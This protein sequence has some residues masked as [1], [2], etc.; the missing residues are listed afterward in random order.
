MPAR[1]AGTGLPGHQSP[2]S[3]KALETPHPATYCSCSSCG[4]QSPPSRKALET[5][6]T[7]SPS[8]SKNFGIKAPPAERHWRP[9]LAEFHNLRNAPKASKP[10][11]PKGI[12]DLPS[13]IPFSRDSI[14]GIKAPPAERHWRHPAGPGSDR[15]RGG[16][17]KAPP[18][19]RHWRH[20][21]NDEAVILGAG[22]IKAPP[23][24]RHWRPRDDRLR[25]GADVGQASKPPQPK[26]IGDA[27]WRAEL[28]RCATG[29]QS[30]PSRKALETHGPLDLTCASP[31]GH[32]SPPSRKALETS[33]RREGLAGSLRRHQSPPSRKA[34]ETEPFG[35][36]LCGLR[37]VA[38]KPPQPK[39]IGDMASADKNACRRSFWHQSPPSR[40]ALETDRQHAG[41][42]L[43][44]ESASKPPQPK[45]IGDE[46]PLRDGVSVQEGIKAPP[47][48][49]HWRP[50]TTRIPATLPVRVAS[51]PPQPKGIGDP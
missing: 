21:H 30:P 50:K 38:S 26:G 27:W 4:H 39:G 45:G 40:K 14:L 48:E 22:G 36:L 20:P 17:I 29:H 37:L 16:G 9:A 41:H 18:A 42:H 34:L 51:K 11:Q 10:P 24:E 35:L 33:R 7:G 25:G 47:A 31:G 46:A 49:R 13:L 23:A 8:T 6:A 1:R 19:E 44:F 32:Q 43:S 5:Q 15:L 2:P 3:R 28:F 12:G